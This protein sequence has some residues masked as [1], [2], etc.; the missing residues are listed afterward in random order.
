MNTISFSA[1]E[2]FNRLKENPV[3]YDL[4]NDDATP[5]PA[6]PRRLRPGSTTILQLYTKVITN[7][8]EHIICKI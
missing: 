2:C 4:V 5:R 3:V 1:C 8:V 6:T 7:F